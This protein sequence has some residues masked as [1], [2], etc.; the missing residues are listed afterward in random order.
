[1]THA[2]ASR[3]L[4]KCDACLQLFVMRVFSHTH[5]HANTRTNFLASRKHEV[6]LSRSNT[7]TRTHTS[8]QVWVVRLEGLMGQWY[9]RYEI[10]IILLNLDSGNVSHGATQFINTVNTSHVVTVHVNLI[11]L[12]ITYVIVAEWL[13]LRCCWRCPFHHGCVHGH[14]S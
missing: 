12:V 1:M 10:I 5:T 9:T 2:Y 13:K 4:F 11:K 14:V 7:H 3:D 8:L 6:P